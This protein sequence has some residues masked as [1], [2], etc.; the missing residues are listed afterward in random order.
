[1]GKMEQVGLAVATGLLAAGCSTAPSPE[2][3]PSTAPSISTEASPSTTPTP[4]LS[5]EPTEYPIIPT[6]TASK[7]PPN[8]KGTL[9]F[10]SSIDPADTVQLYSFDNCDPAHLPLDTPHAAPL[11]TKDKKRSLLKT[12]VVVKDPSYSDDGMPAYAICTRGSYSAAD[13]LRNL[14]IKSAY[15]STEDKSGDEGV[16]TAIY[17]VPPPRESFVA[18]LSKDKSEINLYTQPETIGTKK[19]TLGTMVANFTCTS[20]GLIKSVDASGQI[21]YSVEPMPD[22]QNNQLF[23]KAGIG[24]DA[25]N[26]KDDKQAKAPLT[27]LMALAALKAANSAIKATSSIPHTAKI[28]Y[29]SFS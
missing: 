27:R 29:S 13:V 6:K 24:Y 17:R 7:N 10:T 28:I 8:G 23:S 4:E 11:G 25:V 18:V 26:M 12:T 9:D 19:V 1:M 22:C 3:Q 16:S 5:V 15:G 2:I 20:D 14:I 21:A